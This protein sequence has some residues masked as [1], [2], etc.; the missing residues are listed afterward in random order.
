MTQIPIFNYKHLLQDLNFDFKSKP[1]GLDINPA[2][3]R[4]QC[5]RPKISLNTGL[6]STTGMLL[7][8][9]DW[10]LSNIVFVFNYITKELLI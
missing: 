2:L 7:V 3:I 9:T 1:P 10:T 4:H 8:H 6:I 5:Q